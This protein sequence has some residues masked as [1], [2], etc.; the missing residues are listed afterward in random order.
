[1]EMFV[2]CSF[3][4]LLQNKKNH[5]L[6]FYLGILHLIKHILSTVFDNSVDGGHR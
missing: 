3:T 1:M 6:R 4:S 2:T 5:H